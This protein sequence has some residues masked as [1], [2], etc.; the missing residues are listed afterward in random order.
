MADR[1][2]VTGGSGFLGGAVAE[3][4]DGRA[5][6]SQGRGDLEGVLG[7]TKRKKVGAVFHAGFHVDFSPLT[8]DVESDP[9]G[10]LASFD[11]VLR[12]AEDRE[13]PLVFLSAAGVLGVSTLPRARNEDDV[14]TTD[15]GF[16]AYR[17]T[18]YIQEK[19]ACEER[20]AASSVPWTILYPSTVYGPGMDEGTLRSAA[21]ERPVRVVPPGGTSWLA[22]TDFLDAVERVLARPATGER[23][24]LN[25][26]NLRYGDLVR[27][28]AHARGQKVRVVSLP[29]RSRGVLPAVSDRM[30]VAPAI[31]DSAFGYKY[32]SSARAYRTLGWAPEAQLEQT[33]RDAIG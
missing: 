24:V 32:Y 13:C 16:D 10:N 4:L 7:A 9:H 19:L 8:D 14:G 3:Q 25:G 33:L 5:V 2:L 18:R 17:D 6:V 15:E 28:G 21:S 23:F 20:L 11:R 30:N 12:F 26:G 31:L 27:A 22:L 29:H 1:V